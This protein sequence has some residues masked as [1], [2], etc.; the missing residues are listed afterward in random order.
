MSV[1]ANGIETTFVPKNC[2]LH[3]KITG[4]S[5]GCGSATGSG[6]LVRKIENQLPVADSEGQKATN[7]GLCLVGI[8]DDKKAEVVPSDTN[9]VKLMLFTINLLC[10][11]ISVHSYLV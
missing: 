8:G 7:R 3:A 5:P 10:P 11:S 1:T 2:V 4:G 6:D 9:P